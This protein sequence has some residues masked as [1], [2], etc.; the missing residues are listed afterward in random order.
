[1]SERGN[2]RLGAALGQYVAQVI[3][4]LFSPPFPPFSLARGRIGGEEERN[5]K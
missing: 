4:L 3:S 5:L 2:A 1:V